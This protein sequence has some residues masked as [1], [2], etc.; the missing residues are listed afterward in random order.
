MRGQENN[1]AYIKYVADKLADIKNIKAQ[2]VL[3][4]TEQ[5]ARDL[6]LSGER[7]V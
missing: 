7:Y 3:Q 2:E 1:S 4:V 5:N 6:F